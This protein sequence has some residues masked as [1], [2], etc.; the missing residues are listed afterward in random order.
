MIDCRGL[1][2]DGYLRDL[3]SWNHGVA[4]DLAQQEGIVLDDSHWEIIATLRDFYDRTDNTPS[5]R[6]FVKLMKTS[7]G[8]DKGNSIYL[9]RHFGGSP[10]KTA[11]KIAGLP[12]PTNCL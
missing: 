1:D 12:R 9:M 11:A 10:A 4:A 7:L 2:K 6:P 8:E 3:S 5:M